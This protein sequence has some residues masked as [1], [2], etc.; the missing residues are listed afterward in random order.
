MSTTAGKYYLYPNT[1][2]IDSTVFS[3]DPEDL[4]VTDPISIAQINQTKYLDDRDNAPD[5]SVN[6]EIIDQLMSQNKPLIIATWDDTGV[7]KSSHATLL[8]AITKVGN[9]AYFRVYDS[10]WPYNEPYLYGTLNF[11]YDMDLHVF[12]C[13]GAYNYKRDQCLIQMRYSI[14]T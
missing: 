11:V 8:T 13:S 5:N 1:K 14:K 9:K 4:I 7:E 12:N 2:P 3:W 10:N 6:F